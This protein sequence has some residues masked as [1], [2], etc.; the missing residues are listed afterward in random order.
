MILIVIIV[1]TLVVC[2]KGKSYPVPVTKPAGWEN[3]PETV[4]DK[5]KDDDKPAKPKV[6]LNKR[7]DSDE[8]GS[9]DDNA[10][11]GMDGETKK[12]LKQKYGEKA[13]PLL[14]QNK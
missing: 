11:Y 6:D 12:D 8:S 4:D 3:K 9:D 10:N 7:E 2:L 5:D 13:Q 1:V 14:A